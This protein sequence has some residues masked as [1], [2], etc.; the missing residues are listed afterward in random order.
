MG[1]WTGGELC[2][3]AADRK[4]LEDVESSVR[5]AGTP[6]NNPQEIQTPCR[7]TLKAWDKD[8]LLLRREF[9]GSVAIDLAD[10]LRKGAKYLR[11]CVTAIGDGAMCDTAIGA[12]KSQRC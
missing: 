4:A 2:H 6:A 7:L 1:G 5:S 3:R 9:I 8:P 11:R 12:R 10:F